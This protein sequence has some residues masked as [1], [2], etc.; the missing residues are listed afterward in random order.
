VTGQLAAVIF[1][2]GLIGSI[3]I[4][5]WGHYITA[6]RFGMRVDQFFLG[7]GPTLWSFRKG[8][9][10][11]GVKLL[12]LGGFVRIKGMTPADERLPDVPTALAMRVGRGADPTTALAELLDERGAPPAF[13]RRIVRRFERTLA[14]GKAG[15]GQDEGGVAVVSDQ[16]PA[17]LALE[18]IASEAPPTGRVGDLHHRLLKGDAGRFFHDRPAWQRA[19]VLASGSALHFLQAILLVFLGWLLIGPTVA[20]PVIGSFADAETTEGQVLESAAEA[21]GL[22]PGDRIVAVDGQPTDEFEQVR[23]VVRASP[24][25]AVDLLVD[26]PD[27][28]EPLSFTVVPTAVDDPQTGEQVGLLGFFPATETRPLDA[29]DALYA[30]FIGDGSFTQMLTG[31]LAALGNVFGPEGIA[32]LYAQLTGQ[33]DRGIDGGISL[34]GATQAANEGV[35]AFGA[36]FLFSLLASVNVF[37]GIF[38]ALPLPPLDGGH[39]AVL[40]VEEAVNYKRRRD[41]EP[42]DFKVDPRTVA[43]IAI[44][45]IVFVATI[46]LGL[47]WLDITNPIGF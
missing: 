8:E 21:A 6:R 2:V 22:E 36:L 1:V 27:V 39:L 40:G 38:N 35:D 7:F 20:V 28:E 34:V 9:T 4:H 41:D 33:E 26:R 10:E 37:V 44:P 29:D 25:V 14:A 42:A 12:P 16:D 30:T 46:S 17:R 47:L 43:S 5:E 11:Y 13:A 45:V 31:T 19:I 18:L 23:T 3:M 15:E 32:D 24:G